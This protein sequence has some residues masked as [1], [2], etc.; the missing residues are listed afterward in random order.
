MQYIF[1]IY[2]HYYN[3]CLN[4]FLVFILKSFDALTSFEQLVL[5]SSSVLGETFTRHMLLYLITDNKAD[6]YP[7]QL[8]VA[9]QKLF[10]CKILICAQGDFTEGDLNMI[11]RQNLSTTRNEIVCECKGLT[12]DCK[13]LLSKKSIL[14]L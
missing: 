14:L 6:N 11:Y 12:I 3:I 4:Y 9:I 5:K 1:L 13:F 8:A 2:I 7:F 10:E